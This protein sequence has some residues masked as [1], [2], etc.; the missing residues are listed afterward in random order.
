VRAGHGQ[1]EQVLMNL[2]LNACDSMPRGGTLRIEMTAVETLPSSITRSSAS[3]K[4]HVVL[5]VSDTGGGMD[6]ATRRR[7]FEPFFT[8]KGPGKG[9]GLGLSVV[10]SIVTQ[11]HGFL[12]LQSTVGRG[13]CFSVYLPI[14]AAAP[15]SIPDTGDASVKQSGRGKTILV[16]EDDPAVRRVTSGL[17]RNKGYNVL[18]ADGGAQ[19]LQ[20]A[21]NHSGGFD[22]FLT[23]VVMPGLQGPE[24]VS[25]L[26]EL[27]PDTAV[28]F[29][30]GYT[31]TERFFD[32]NLNDRR[33]FLQKP[34]SSEALER[35]L[36]TLLKPPFTPSAG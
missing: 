36:R 15:S 17:L 6:E 1:I 18:V 10:D 35:E 23:D 28:L 12:D 4:P 7:V 27:Y 32:L 5:R 25:S 26:L 11:H 8:T 13:S 22:L 29:V 3:Q 16:I 14:V 2:A 19:A 9:T 34:F 33:T 30:S 31:D 20:I 21:Q 24:L